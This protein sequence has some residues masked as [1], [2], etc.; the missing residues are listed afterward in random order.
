MTSETTSSVNT[1]EVTTTFSAVLSGLHGGESSMKATIAATVSGTA[2][3]TKGH[4]SGSSTCAVTTTF[5]AE[6]GKTRPSTDYGSL[7]EIEKRRQRSRYSSQYG[8]GTVYRRVFTCPKTN[9]ENILVDELSDGELMWSDI[10][11]DDM[12]LGYGPEQPRIQ[13]VQAGQQSKGAMQEIVVDFVSLDTT[14]VSSVGYKETRRT[15][16]I[17][18]SQF[19]D[20]IETWGVALTETSPNVPEEGDYL[21]DNSSSSLNPVCVSVDIMKNARKGCVVVH[22]IWEQ[23][24][25]E[26]L[27][28]I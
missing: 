6:I 8:Y 22:S 21:D 4:H 12:T 1:V 18:K 13:S 10:A 19:K 14:S 2:D 27:V 9:L 5:D 11:D 7:H 25:D 23:L 3:G 24:R 26:V 16:P 20:V 15:S 17:R 28:D